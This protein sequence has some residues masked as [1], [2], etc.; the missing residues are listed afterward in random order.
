M[1][2]VTDIIF[3]VLGIA[4]LCPFITLD[5]A[6][7]ILFL[8]VNGD[9]LATITTMNMIVMVIGL[10]L[11]AIAD[12]IRAVGDGDY[13]KDRWSTIVLLIGAVFVFLSFAMF[14]NSAG[15][16]SPSL[17]DFTYAKSIVIVLSLVWGIIVLIQ[18]LWF[19]FKARSHN[20]SP[21]VRTGVFLND[22]E[23][24]L[25]AIDEFDKG[26]ILKKRSKG[27]DSNA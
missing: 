13:K 19:S 14:I 15:L 17:Q 7:F 11:P 21:E 16:T 25:N 1:G 10:L 18:V 12:I 4:A 8:M 24:I 6:G 22:L 27:G 20:R 26:T 23:R 5:I 2:T 3:V 9:G